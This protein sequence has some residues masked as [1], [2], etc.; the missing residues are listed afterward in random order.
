MKQLLIRMRNKFAENRNEMIR[1]LLL[2]EGFGF[3]F[4]L[5]CICGYRLD[6]YDTVC[7]DAGMV[8]SGLALA[9]VFGAVIAVV[10]TFAAEC[11]RLSR[12]KAQADVRDTEKH[13][14]AETGEAAAGKGRGRYLLSWLIC[15]L[16][17]LICW[18]PVFLA[19]YPAVFSYDAEAQLYQVISGDYST[20]H[21]L[22]HTLLMGICMKAGFSDTGINA[23]MALYAVIQMVLMALM[24][25]WT[26]AQL[27]KLKVRRVWFIVYAAF[28]CF[29]PV[30]P[31]LAVSTTKDVLF[32]GFAV[33]FT[34]LVRK[35]V[36][37]ETAADKTA[38]ENGV[39][40]SMG[41]YIK[42]GLAAVLM[43]LFRNNAVY[44]LAAA[45][46]ILLLVLLIRRIKG[47]ELR[48]AAL[49]V[50]FTAAL[51]ISCLLNSGMKVML[52]AE[53]GSPREA[54]SIPIQQMARVKALHAS[55]LDEAL[56]ADLDGLISSEWADRYDEHLADPIKERISMKQPALFVKTWIKLGLKYP[57]EYIDAWLLT[58]EGAWY[59]RDRS[60][61][62]IY[63]EGKLTGFGYLST[64]IRNMPEGFEVTNESILPG[65][66]DFLEGIVSDNSFESVPVLRL[67][68]APALYI[69]IMLL[70]MHTSIV[71][72]DYGTLA[73]LLFPLMYFMTLLLSPAILVR[74]M[75]PY[76]L[77][78]FLPALGR[79]GSSKDYRENI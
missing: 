11:C 24:L 54:L 56:G 43:L 31:I 72:R 26:L 5:S 48:F 46:V 69:W 62:R 22:I 17:L 29:F 23:G 6:K 66:R 71:H 79:I 77:L 2:S 28:L 8:I 60:C 67:I 53:S 18:L 34:L 38:A 30:N 74:Y 21:P 19:Y 63:G 45:T 14:G 16:V 59:I 36:S 4:S 68:F 57:G 35:A 41:I 13:V 65:L 44:A 12:E 78:A 50:T 70:Y 39:K 37:D 33:V 32:A 51:I 64:D 1:T 9:L 47:K 42:I 25:G 20:H 73:V 75:Y 15:T 3:C 7:R 52:N 76:M 61:N 58:T 27:L 55:E 49:T 40:H 10:Y